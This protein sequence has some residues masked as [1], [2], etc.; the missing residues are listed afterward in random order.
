MLIKKI[1]SIMSIVLYVFL[2]PWPVFVMG[3]YLWLETEFRV[4]VPLS[5]IVFEFLLGILLLLRLWL[6]VKFKKTL[7]RIVVNILLI[8]SFLLFCGSLIYIYAPLL[9]S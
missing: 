6:T 8:G 2:L 1:L 5:L 4:I 9:W 3:S 7:W